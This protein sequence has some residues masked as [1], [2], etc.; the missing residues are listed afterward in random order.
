MKKNKMNKLCGALFIAS[1]VS[2]LILAGAKIGADNLA[3]TGTKAPVTEK[4]AIMKEF[5]PS[6]PKYVALGF[7]G[8]MAL[9]GGISIINKS[10][11]K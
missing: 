4:Q 6:D 5:C 3:D 8:A 7:F 9:I 11:E 2:T 10:K 1:G